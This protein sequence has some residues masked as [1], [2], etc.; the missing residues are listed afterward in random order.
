[1]SLVLHGYYRSSAA[2]RVRIALALKG[3]AADQVFHHLRR[4][5]QPFH[6]KPHVAAGV[7]ESA[8][9]RRSRQRRE[10]RR[11]QLLW[12]HRGRRGGDDLFDCTCKLQDSYS[13]Y[14]MG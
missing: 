11:E 13:G 4:G 9:D 7:G 14:C 6:R 12:R 1:M 8:G 10:H 5:E 3:L 2:F